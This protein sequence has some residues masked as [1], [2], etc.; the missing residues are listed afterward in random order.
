VIHLRID[1]LTGVSRSTAFD[2]AGAAE[3]PPHPARIFSAFVEAH[4]N[5]HASDEGRA[6]LEWLESLPAPSLTASDAQ[7]RTVR[8]HFVP[9]NDRGMMDN[10]V[11]AHLADLANAARAV[12]AATDPKQARKASKEVAKFE[13]RLEATAEKVRQGAGTTNDKQAAEAL[14]GLPGPNQLKQPRSFP[15]VI[16]DDPVVWIH[17]EGDPSPSQR[18]ALRAIA[19]N[20]V[21]IGH[22]SSLVSCRW[23]DEAPDPTHIPSDRGA[24]RLRTVRTGQLQALDLE[25][26]RSKATLPRILP[27]ASTSYALASEAAQPPTPESVFGEDWIV[28]RRLEGDRL[29]V[30]RSVDVARATRTAMLAQNGSLPGFI[31]GHTDGEAVPHVAFV[32]LPFVG[33][34]HARGQLLGVAIVPP[35]GLDLAR[36]EAFLQ[37]VAKW[38]LHHEGTDDEAH[39]TIPLSIGR[40]Q[41]HLERVMPGQRVPAT[42]RPSTWC[43]PAYEW[44]SVTPVA[45]GRNP[46]NL[47]SD[48]AEVRN[49]AVAKAKRFLVDA[50]V[51]AG[52]PEPIHVEV[53]MPAPL[54]GSQPVN[55]FPSFPPQRGRHRRVRVHVHLAFAQKVRGPILLGAGR[56]QGTGLFRP[57]EAADAKR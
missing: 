42:L 31:T 5:G 7:A 38:V 57:L 56:Y 22:S 3:W 16:P 18:D 10:K 46:G 28:L 52:L 43:R 30:T 35:R 36:H 49:R 39:Q 48:R 20:V 50:V 27:F 23:S 15:A 47:H 1:Y 34:E 41:M 37:A 54:R 40:N 11:N 14:R 55:R 8:T 9:V 25:F 33:H 51:R 6:A 32:P 19:S 13:K 45:L 21:R 26:E 29:S 2:D 12:E 44:A 17:W 24:L 4:Y 53:L